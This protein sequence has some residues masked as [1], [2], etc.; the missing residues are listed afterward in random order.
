MGDLRLDMYPQGFEENDTLRSSFIRQLTLQQLRRT[1]SPLVRRRTKSATIPRTLMRYWH[2]PDDLPEDVR[3]CIDSW[4][5]LREHGFVFQ[6][7][8]DRSAAEYIAENFG[9]RERKAF[10]R[11]RHPAM[12]SDYFRMCFILAE[13]GFYV[14][15]DDALLGSGWRRLFQDGAMKIQPLC[16][17]IPT[18]QMVPATEIW[19][20]DLSGRGRIF[21]VNNNPL[22]APAHH[23]ILRRAL[24]RATE[25]LLKGGTHLEIQS[26]TGPGNLSAALAAHARD[27]GVAGVPA[28]FE[29]IRDWET[30]AE[31]RW[32]LSYRRDSRNW[33]NMDNDVHYG[34]D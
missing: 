11:C 23:P 3:E 30:I 2:D 20:A 28:D 14:D 19:R 31:T 18:G 12:R 27:T 21:Y 15:A 34:L 32:D 4:N 6:T 8:C 29:L 5:R 10:A 7:F 13:G 24:T 17:D 25:R 9:Q 33:R 1:A 16:Y 26:T 22:A